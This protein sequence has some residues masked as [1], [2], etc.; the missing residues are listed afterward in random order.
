MMKVAGCVAG[1]IGYRPTFPNRQIME[2]VGNNLEPVQIPSSRKGQLCLPFFDTSPDVG[3]RLPN[4]KKQH[5][6]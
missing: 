3:H 5:G 1:A 2:K 4:S 6:N